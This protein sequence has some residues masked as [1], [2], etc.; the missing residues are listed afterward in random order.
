MSI[1]STNPIDIM[2]KRELTPKQERFCREYFVDFVAKKAAIRTGYSKRT[3]EKYAYKLIRNSLIIER[4]NQLA[5]EWLKIY[6]VARVRT[7]QIMTN[8]IE[9]DPAK[10]FDKKG[11]LL[12]IRKIDLE[13]RRAIASIDHRIDTLKSG[14]RVETT[15]IRLVDKPKT[16]ELLAKHQQLLTDTIELSVQT[17]VITLPAKVPIGTPVEV[18][19][20][21]NIVSE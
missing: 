10:L 19:E 2:V 9:A 1:V 12:P 13:T 4:L 8:I 6:R 17:Q 18:D 5:E 15:R 3:A 14:A 21:G 7:V 16:I 20:E 11:K